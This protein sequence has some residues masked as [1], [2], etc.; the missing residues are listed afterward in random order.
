MASREI[1]LSEIGKA[2]I[3]QAMI[4]ASHEVGGID[5]F[6]AKL[7]PHD[8]A[9]FERSMEKAHDEFYKLP[10]IGTGVTEHKKR[11][12][13]HFVLDTPVVIGMGVAQSHVLLEWEDE[14]CDPSQRN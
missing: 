7:N 2:Q 11:R 13:M 9:T 10:P 6:I 5:P 8:Y 14:I 12:G 3:A 4:R 1:A